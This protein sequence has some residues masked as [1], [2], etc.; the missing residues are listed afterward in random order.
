MFTPISYQTG[1]ELKSMEEKYKA[2]R[3]AS[4][5]FGLLPILAS[6]GFVLYQGIAYG[7]YH[8][9]S[10]LAGLSYGGLILVFGVLARGL[11]RVRGLI[12]IILSIWWFGLPLLDP[13]DFPWQWIFLGFG[14]F[15]PGLLYLFPLREGKS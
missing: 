15:I 9:Q 14:Y 6:S 2:A 13:E 5:V 12:L 8:F 11:Y 7:S 1:M 3:I 4:L 10:L